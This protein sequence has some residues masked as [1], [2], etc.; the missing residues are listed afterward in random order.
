MREVLM[1]W[2]IR[3]NIGKIDI[4]KYLENKEAM[5]CVS[6]GF[7]KRSN[8]VL[9]GAIGAIDGWLVKIRRSNN[10]MDGVTDPVPYYSRK[11]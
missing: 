3:P 8:G 4:I 2:I 9:T 6:N 11:F 10:Y 5:D 7:A 1:C